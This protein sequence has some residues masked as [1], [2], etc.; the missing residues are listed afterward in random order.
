MTR[1]TG[2]K[3]LLGVVLLMGGGGGAWWVLQP[4]P[5][6]ATPEVADGEEAD[7]SREETEDL[8]RKIGYVQ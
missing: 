1:S 7:P 8:M 4:E 2:F 3:A 5:E 6:Q